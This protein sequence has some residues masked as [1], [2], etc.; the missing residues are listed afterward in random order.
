LATNAFGTSSG[1]AQYLDKLYN[2]SNVLVNTKNQINA[3]KNSIAIS[4]INSQLDDAKNNI[5]ITTDLTY[6]QDALV[7]VFLEWNAYTDSSVKGSYQKSCTSNTRDYWVSNATLCPDSYTLINAGGSNIGNPSCLVLSSWSAS[8]V[9]TRYGTAPSGC[10]PT[11]SSDFSTISS[12]STTYFN[13][14]TSYSNDN[15]NLIDEVK[16][17]TSNINS[18]FTSMA[19]KML[20]LLTRVDGVISPLVDIFQKFVG[21]QG[22]FSLINCCKFFGFLIVLKIIK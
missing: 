4:S 22:L 20:D 14:M 3:N 11:G 1:S 2:V 9:S 6:N 18:S 13:S 5:V 19:G 8:Q 12:A 7:N 21:D 15:S 17:E 16:A 10:G